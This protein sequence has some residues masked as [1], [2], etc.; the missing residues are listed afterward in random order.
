MKYDLQSISPFLCLVL[1]SFIL[2]L[3]IVLVIDKHLSK[4]TIKMPKQQIILNLDENTRR[5]FNFSEP[6]IENFSKLKNNNVDYSSCPEQVM[7][8]F[9]RIKKHNY[10]ENSELLNKKCNDKISAN[11]RELELEY[12]SPDEIG[13]MIT[14]VVPKTF[15]KLYTSN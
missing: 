8:T 10:I 11:E 5:K 7:N 12:N 6:I 9:S 14:V 3:I 2:G 15:K 1:L 13:K 4:V